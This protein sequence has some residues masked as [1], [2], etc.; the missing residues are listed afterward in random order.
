VPDVATPPRYWPARE[1]PA[2]AY[3]PGLTPHPLRDPA[4]HSFAVAGTPPPCPPPEKWRED[5]SWLYG[6]DLY[7]HGY[8]W[9]AHETWETCWWSV[10]AS[11]PHRDLVQGLIQLA[12]ACLRRRM[13]P[14]RGG[15][16]VGQRALIKLER[17]RKQLGGET[18]GLDLDGFADRARAYLEGNAAFP[19]IVLRV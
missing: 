10:A 14:S 13:E 7:N 11:P 6:V 1:L 12:A 18:M 15:L 9:E 16:S 17:A 8:F 3:T 19:Y 4:G 2:Y 5:A